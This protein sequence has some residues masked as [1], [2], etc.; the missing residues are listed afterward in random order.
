MLRRWIS[1]WHFARL[2]QQLKFIVADL[3]LS[4][5]DTAAE[6]LD[7]I[8]ADRPEPPSCQRSL[9]PMTNDDKVCSNF[10]REFCNSL[11]GIT[12]FQPGG[13]RKA[14]RLKALHTFRIG[15]R[16]SGFR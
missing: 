16:R 4:D 12:S 14:Q 5:Q 10:F 3:R 15:D 7:Q 13:G 1:G 2:L 9:W 6:T 11:P 8:T